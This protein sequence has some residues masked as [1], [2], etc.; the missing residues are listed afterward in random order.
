MMT[1]AQRHYRPMAESLPFAGEVEVARIA[2]PDTTLSDVVSVRAGRQADGQILYRVVTDNDD[3]C[4]RQS[5]PLPL[6][7][8]ELV[9]MIGDAR[10][11]GAYWRYLLQDCGQRRDDLPRYLVFSTDY[12]ALSAHFARQYRRLSRRP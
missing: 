7:T 10:Q 12:P 5:S 4:H 11:A 1:V 6:S 9:R 3:E 2:Y 8:G